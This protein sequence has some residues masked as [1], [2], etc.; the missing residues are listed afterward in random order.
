MQMKQKKQ[1]II[2]IIHLYYKYMSQIIGLGGFSGSG[3][4]SSLAYLDPK[5]TF[6]ISCTPKQLSIKGFRKNYKKLTQTKVKNK[7]GK[8]VVKVEGNWFYSNDFTKVENIMKIVDAKMPNIK[9]LVIDDANYLLSQEVMARALE[10]G[11]D[12]HTEFAMHY[13]TLLTDAMNLRDDLVV[14]FIS[15]IVNDGS[16]LDPNYKL[17][18]TGK[19]LDRSVNIDGMFN[20]LLYAEKLIDSV[21]NEVSYKFRTHSLGKDTC[22]STTGCFENLYI[23]P[24]MKAV[25]DRINEFENE[26]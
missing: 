13:Y 24:N 18:T 16:D 6:I 7:E 25:I 19:L 2:Q 15:H 26:D 5:E 23:E 9:I 11:Y 8:E 14:V 4:S 12:K 1:I 17:F 3:K 10:K 21:T 22:R 20:Y